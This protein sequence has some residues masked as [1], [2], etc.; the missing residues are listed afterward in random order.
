VI[1]G[2]S[3]SILTAAY[4]TPCTSTMIQLPP[5]LITFMA[6][7][8]SL[9]TSSV[10]LQAYKVG[11]PLISCAFLAASMFAF[12][13]SSILLNS[14]SPPISSS[15]LMIST[16]PAAASKNSF[17]PTSGV[18]PVHGLIIL[19]NSGLFSAPRY[20]RIPSIPNFGPWKSFTKLSG[21]S[22]SRSFR[23][24]ID[25]MFPVIVASNSGMLFLIFT[26]GYPILRM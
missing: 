10:I 5:L 14:R 15:S 20:L 3:A 11:S 22:M 1:S 9:L 7:S 8:F 17:A 2:S 4:P 23:N 16:P 26:T 25:M 18:Y 24:G 19:F 21:K 6:F 12:T 13:L